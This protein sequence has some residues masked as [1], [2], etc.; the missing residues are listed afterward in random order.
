MLVLQSKVAEAAVGIGAFSLFWDLGYFM[1]ML[2]DLTRK[3]CAV[4]PVPWFN[5][6]THNSIESPV[7][8]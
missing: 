5:L 1:L 7:L 3:L 4:V 6:L 8:R 2:N